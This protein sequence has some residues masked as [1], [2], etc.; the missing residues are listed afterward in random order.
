MTVNV[1]WTLPCPSQEFDQGPLVEHQFD[2][3]V[4][5]YDREG[6]T[7]EYI[8]EEIVFRGIEAYRFLTPPQCREEHLDAYDRLIEVAAFEWAPD[9][10]GKHLRIYMDDVGCLDVLCS[11]YLPPDDSLS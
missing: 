8:W 1:L 9:A 5:R 6:S 2:R 11:A 4:L 7:G 10:A 3:L